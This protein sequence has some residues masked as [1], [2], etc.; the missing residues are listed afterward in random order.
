MKHPANQHRR[1]SILFIPGFL[2]LSGIFAWMDIPLAVSQPVTIPIASIKGD[3]AMDAANPIWESVPGV[4]VPLS[5]QTITTP[6]HPNISVKT[7]MVKMATNGQDIG[8]WANWGD[9]TLNNTTIGPQD[10]RDQ[11]AIQ[12][13][14]QDSGAPPF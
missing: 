7:V 3:I 8:V 9:Q 2:I 6:M 4:V 13:P 1:A 12:F 10:F 14:V 11:M 5:G